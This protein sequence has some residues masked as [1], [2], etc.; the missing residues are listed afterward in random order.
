MPLTEKGEEI[1]SNME[2]QY[3]SERGEK[4]FYASKNAGT[5]TGVD[6]ITGYPISPYAQ[7]DPFQVRN[8]LEQE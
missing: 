7:Y 5:I 2:Q 1:L 8:K 4:I 6:Q 3:G